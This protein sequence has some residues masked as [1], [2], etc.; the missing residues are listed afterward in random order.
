VLYKI[1]YYRN[2]N[3]IFLVGKRN[4]AKVLNYYAAFKAQENQRFS[5]SFPVSYF[6]ADK[7]FA[8]Y[9]YP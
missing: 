1:S 2:S 3:C 9:I 5:A 8:P 4:V 7:I 6:I